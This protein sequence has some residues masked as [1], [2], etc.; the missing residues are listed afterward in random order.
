MVYLTLGDRMCAEI[1]A[2]S[3]KTFSTTRTGQLSRQLFV[4]GE[5]AG[6]ADIVLDMYQQSELQK[7]LDSAT[8]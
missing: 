3:M 7:L 8:G 1:R 4:K 6:S 2:L 5:L